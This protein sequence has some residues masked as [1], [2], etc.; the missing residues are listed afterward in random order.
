MT[1]NGVIA[2]EIEDAR[3]ATLLGD[4]APNSETKR[5]ATLFAVDWAVTLEDSPEMATY[6]GLPGYGDRWSDQSPAALEKGRARARTRLAVIESIDRAALS[7]DDQLNYDLFLDQARN[8]VEG[9]RF[10]QELLA[11]NQLGGVHQQAASIMRMM[12]N[13]SVMQLEDQV[14]RLEGLPAVIDQTIALLEA[15][16]AAG[17]TPPAITMREVPQQVR[18][19]IVDTPT[20]N[21]LLKGFYNLPGSIPPE[22]GA[23]LRQQAEDVYVTEIRPAWEKLETFVR[24]RYLPA[25]R[26]GIAAEALPDGKA[27]Y[28]YA[29]KTRTTL[30]LTPEEIHDIGLSE[31]ARIRA[32]MESIKDAVEFD[33]T[34]EAFFDFMRTDPRFFHT[35]RQALLA[36]Y[37][38]IA[39]RADLE[40]PKLFGLLPRL[41]YGVVEV[42]SYA[43]KSQT[44]AYYNSGGLE[45]GR[46]GI[47]FANTYAL[48]TRP[49]WEMEA[50][51]LHE[52]V[53]GHHHQLSLQQELEELPPFRRYSWS[54]T[55]F[56]EGWG[57]YSESL[58]EE[59]GFYTDPYA[60]FGQ[61]TYE[62][63][64]AVRLV[65]DTGMHAK[66]WSRQQAIDYFKA[67]APKT[68]NDIIV[69]IDRYIVWPGQALAYKLGELK[70]K[71]LR[72]RATAA[73]GQRFNIRDFHDEALRHGALPLSV[74]EA[75]IDRWIAAQ[76]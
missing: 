26:D 67:N 47:F 28:A 19:M 1:P 48:H 46:A 76:R 66:G 40:M 13:R 7:P 35:D 10:P 33:G 37:R 58:G 17:V 49:R 11:I 36:E 44:T 65:V 39:K 6:V 60:K 2:Q 23:L 64:R 4:D 31:V 30:A 20:D 21:P 50:L 43:E 14:A 42:P 8:G 25:T 32:E 53:P 74:L 45:A 16:M 56:V 54:Y 52:A 68:E 70:F 57:L 5:L 29:V 69:E 27:W 18:N 71:E 9:Q 63:W 3:Y 24:E 38:D 75:N 62:M 34:L 73:L 12:P 61:L 51:T 41:P 72:A 15:G 59:M 55:G 22:E